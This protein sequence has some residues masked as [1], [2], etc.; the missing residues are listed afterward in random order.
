MTL[1]QLLEG[2]IKKNPILTLALLWPITS[3]LFFF[4]IDGIAGL[5]M[6]LYQLGVPILMLCGL[7]TATSLAIWGAIKEP[8]LKSKWTWLVLFL[9]GSLVMLML[10]FA[11][12]WFRY[13]I[14]YTTAGEIACSFLGGAAMMVIIYIRKRAKN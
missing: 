7:P 8:K 9:I 13:Y 4:I 10:E 6:T 14:M 1:K 12:S 5:I 2:W 11:V 3:L